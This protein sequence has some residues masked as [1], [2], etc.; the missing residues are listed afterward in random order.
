MKSLRAHAVHE[1]LHLFLRISVPN[2]VLP[3][4]ILEV[5]IQ[6]LRSGLMEDIIVRLPRRA[7]YAPH[8]F[9]RTIVSHMGAHHI[10]PVDNIRFIVPEGFR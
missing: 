5:A 4:E 2:A 3:E 9:D 1:E 7:P 10:S 6:M 8:S